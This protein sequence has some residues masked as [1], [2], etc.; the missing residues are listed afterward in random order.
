MTK[1]VI[2]EWDF[3][4]PNYFEEPIEISRQNYIMTIEAGKATATI[5]YATFN[6]NASMRNEL[7]DGLNSRFLAVLL[8]SHLAYKLSNPK[9][10]HVH[11]DGHTDIFLEISSSVSKMSI[12][13]LDLQ[14][15]D[16]D[17]NIISDSRRE[18]IEKKKKR[19]ELVAT[20]KPNDPL[21]A[22]L[23]HS[24]QTAVTDPNNELVHLYEIRD[25]IS[26]KFGN[27]SK[28]RKKLAITSSQWSRLGQLCND[29]PLK[30][31]RHRGKAVGTLRDASE[32][33]LVEAREISQ[34]MIEA[35]LQ[36]LEGLNI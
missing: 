20:H 6:A 28:V 21:V 10:T 19:A 12:G 3:S 32:S 24:Y 34:T 7:H 9:M 15:A 11:P 13:T 5:D 35:Y 27:E 23:L 33:E 29:E 25:A 26:K 18:R 36:Y 22:A 4:P 16:K 8:F 1:T 31:G 14:V 30:Q 2:L 17:G